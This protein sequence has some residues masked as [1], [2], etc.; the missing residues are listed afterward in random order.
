M[1]QRGN[2]DIK[3][4]ENPLER[5]VFLRTMIRHLSGVL[6]ETV[7]LD[8]AKGFISTVGRNIGD[9]INNSYK[10]IIKVNKLNPKQVAAVLVD[11]KEKING[12]FYI[13]EMTD[14]KVVFGN[15]KCPFEDKVIG[16]PSLCMMTSNVFGTIASENLG[17]AKVSL[18]ETIAQGH[19]KCK[20]TVYF[21]FNDSEAKGAEGQEYYGDD[22]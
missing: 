1:K 4:L 19:G 11:L 20:V 6:E 2:E 12:D 16:R 21:D 5:G 10:N 14:K 13:V 8:E 22:I 7:G 15:T 9:E 18:A 3:N 17:Y